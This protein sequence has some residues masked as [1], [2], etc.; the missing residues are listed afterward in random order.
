MTRPTS[1]GSARAAGSGRA[2]HPDEATPRGLRA[3][4]EQLARGRHRD[5]QSG[6]SPRPGDPARAPRTG[7]TARAR[8]TLGRSRPVRR[9]DNSK[10][11][12]VRGCPPGEHGEPVEHA[13]PVEPP[14]P[15]D[16]LRRTRPLQLVAR[17]RQPARPAHRDWFRAASFNARGR[18]DRA[19]R[20]DGGRER[21][22]P[23]ERSQSGS[24]GRTSR[25]RPG[26]PGWTSGGSC[27]KGPSPGT[28]VEQADGGERRSGRAVTPVG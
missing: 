21:T 2:L 18:G 26:R 23:D 14:G 17:E 19:E 1:A 27:T 8:A 12:G 25:Q 10:G 5:G 11:G 15:R 9:S 6:A 3:R 20:A 28:H 7:G 16:V 24:T 13:E 22:E 4:A